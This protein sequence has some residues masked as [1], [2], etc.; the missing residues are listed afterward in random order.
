M[1]NAMRRAWINQP[2]TRQLLHAEH[3][4][5]VLACNDEYTSSTVVIYYLSG[6]VVSA[7]VPKLCL[8]PGW[9][10]NEVHRAALIS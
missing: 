8:S 4:T 10:G 3:G 9:T 6:P 7:V 1:R 2:S 5:N